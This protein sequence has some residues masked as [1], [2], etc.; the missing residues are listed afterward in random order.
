MFGRACNRCAQCV[1]V[2]R[3]DAIETG[4][5]Y[6]ILP[7]ECIVCLDCLAVCPEGGLGFRK[8]LRPD[9][10][11]E[12][13]LTRRQF[14]TGLAASAAGVVLLRTGVG[15]KQPDTYLIRPPG[16]LDEQEFLSRCVRCGQCMRVC[17]TSGLQPAGAEGGAA[18]V[19]TPRLVPRLGHCEY[20]CNACGQV[21]PSGAIPPLSLEQ[22]REATLGVAVID[23]NRCWPWSQDVP[24]IV[25]EEM[26]PVPDKAIRISAPEGSDDPW[27]MQLPVVLA[28]L[29]IGCGIC[30]FQ[31][32]VEGEAAI[33]VYR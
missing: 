15:A 32:P 1:Q 33:R 4:Q 9:P 12:G 21:C 2:C 14:L 26:C 20:G 22:K 29:C 10:V 18:G 5:G 31:C 11:R 16:V 24:C 8:Q 6:E 19:W 7:S 27:A 25:C 23:R 30:E 3:V 17:P 28:D 13:D